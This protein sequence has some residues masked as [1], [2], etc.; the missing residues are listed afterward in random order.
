MA[1]KD[2]NLKPVSVSEIK[3]AVQ[4]QKPATANIK[5]V[6]P[7]VIQ[8]SS[9]KLKSK[10]AS[11]PTIEQLQEELSKKRQEKT[12]ISTNIA[13]IENKINNLTAKY[14][15]YKKDGKTKKA[16][17]YSEQIKDEKAKLKAAKSDKSKV[18]L[19]IS[20]LTKS[21]ENKK[22]IQAANAAHEENVK[23][24]LADRGTATV[25]YTSNYSKSKLSDM[26]PFTGK[27]IMKYGA[28]A[29]NKEKIFMI[30]N[31]TKAMAANGL[32]PMS[33][34]DYYNKF[35][36][37]GFID[38]FNTDTVCTEWLFFTKPD[39]YLFDGPKSDSVTLNTE[40]A[41]IPFFKDAAERNK[42]ALLQLQYSVKDKNGNSNPFMYL[43]SNSVTSKLDLPGISVDSQE[44]TQ[45]IMGTNIQ[46]R[47]HSF[48]SDNSY[49]FSLSFTDTPQLEIYTM[50][51]VYDEYLKMLKMGEITKFDDK[52]KAYILSRAMPEQ[53]SVYKFLIGSDGETILYYAKLTG[54][55]FTDV[56]RSDFGDP[57]QDG[58]K[59]SL[60]F[61]AQFVEDNNPMIL[62]DFNRISPNVINGTYLDVYNL[63]LGMVDNQW[64]TFPKVVRVNNDDKRV[65]RRG[66]HHDYRMKWY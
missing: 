66:T 28:S 60:S 14:N 10:S 44:S 9:V 43:L 51:K 30:E 40:L 58:F 18:V 36:R 5:T 4:Q 61:H 16:K 26:S 47:G 7:M 55:Y 27:N 38:P 12:K 25:S 34:I 48:K 63:S 21:I 65:A 52:H 53:F 17:E 11:D 2:I 45:T 6:D 31:L 64:A 50:V 23:N 1:E 54:V 56:P 15:K 19:D 20:A 42:E 37:Y 24:M 22:A 59:F 46:Y 13:S 62:T 49:D 39:L 41:G 33:D 35:N 29:T 8:N 57:S 32:F 3:N